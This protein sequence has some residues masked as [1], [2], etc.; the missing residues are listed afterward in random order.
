M[1]AGLANMGP[2]SLRNDDTAGARA[3]VR[4]R[5]RR[6]RLRRGRRRARRG[7]RG[8]RG[9][10]AARAPTG[11]S[12]AARSR[13]TRSTSA[14]P[15]PAGAQAAAALRLALERTGTAPADVDYICAHGTG[16]RANDSSRRSRSGRRSA[17]AADGVGGQL[18][19][20]DGR[21]SH[22]CGGCAVARWRAC[23]RCAT[24]SCR[25]RST[26]TRRIPACDLDYVPLVARGGRGADGGGQR[27][28]LRRAELR[29]RAA[30]ALTIGSVA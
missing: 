8:A 5:P 17:P 4:R 12:P 25:R 18:A 15:S 11:A 10:R 7:V 19:Q 27:V 14:R 29:G 22:R 26:S 20:V 3:P 24:A 30:R 28:R 2:L 23:W 16:T 1:F 6:L 21:A 9:G 13:A